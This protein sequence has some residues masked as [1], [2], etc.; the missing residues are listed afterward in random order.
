VKRKARRKMERARE[1]KI[2]RLEGG[3]KV[4]FRLVP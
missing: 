3:V 1:E 4:G 2:R